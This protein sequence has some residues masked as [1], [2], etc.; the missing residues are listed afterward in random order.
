[1]STT[2]NTIYLIRNTVNDKKY[3]G[4]TWNSL[5][6]RWASGYGRC[7]HLDRAI[8]KYGKKVFYY[9]VLALCS[10]QETADYL[11]SHYI[12]DYDTQNDKH[13][14]NIR[15][16]GE[17]SQHSSSSIEKMTNSKRNKSPLKLE[18][19][20]S[21][22]NDFANGI[23]MPQIAKQY[24]VSKGAIANVIYFS[25]WKD[26]GGPLPTKKPDK[27]V[28][29]DIINIRQLYYDGKTSIIELAKQFKVDRGTIYDIVNGK[30]WKDIPSLYTFPIIPLNKKIIKSITKEQLQELLL[31]RKDGLTYAQLSTKL[32]ITIGRIR[33]I[34]ARNNL[35]KTRH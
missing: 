4:Q 22:R 1:M 33:R 19:I 18:W 14:Y 17:G 23:Q 7:I 15:S 10:D 28:P 12:H 25:T 13:G 31:L 30:I 24:G 3:V 26:A 8:K 20:K 11:E 2:T 5:S 9:E 21:I 35:T 16:G 27:L 34:L 29:T 6:K 32:G